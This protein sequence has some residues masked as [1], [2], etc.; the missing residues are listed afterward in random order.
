MLLANIGV[1]QCR[2][3][4]LFYDYYIAKDDVDRL[5]KELQ[6]ILNSEAKE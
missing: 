4:D 3:G 2:I 6:E 5:A 1:S